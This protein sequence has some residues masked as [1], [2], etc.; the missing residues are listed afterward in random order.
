[1]TLISYI[2]LFEFCLYICLKNR[3]ELRLSN[4]KLFVLLKD[5]QYYSMNNSLTWN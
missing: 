4:F 3:S 2:C 1:M 5:F